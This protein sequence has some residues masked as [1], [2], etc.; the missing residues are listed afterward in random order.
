VESFGDVVIVVELELDAC[1]ELDCEVVEETGFIDE[2]E[3]ELELNECVED[4]DAV[5]G[6]KACSY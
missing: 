3:V 5:L 1:D 6:F 4:I 2:I